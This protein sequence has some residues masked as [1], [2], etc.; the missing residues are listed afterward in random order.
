MNEKSKEDKMKYNVI[1][2]L[3]LAISFS[4]VQSKEES[5]IHNLHGSDISYNLLSNKF[6]DDS[7]LLDYNDAGVIAIYLPDTI[8][9]GD[10]VRPF[11]KIKNFGSDTADI[12]TRMKI[13]SSYNQVRSKTLGPGNEDT[14][15]FPSWAAFRVAWMVVVCSTELLGDQNPE[16]DRLTDTIYVRRFTYDIGIETIPVPETIN[17]AESAKVTIRNYGM[18]RVLDT[19]YFLFQLYTRDTVPVFILSFSAFL[20]LTP[21]DTARVGNP[22]PPFFPDEEGILS[23]EIWP[24]NDSNPHNNIKFK[25]FF[26]RFPAIQ[27]P[28]RSLLYSSP[29]K[30]TVMRINQFRSSI[31]KSEPE[32]NIFGSDGRRIKVEGMK[33]GIY[34]IKMRTNVKKVIIVK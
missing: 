15:T 31:I 17:L 27:E 19:C 8:G 5:L 14:V 29:F 2:L 16:N 13:G 6:W 9:Y 34:F 4:Q 18:S 26:I 7:V 1:F 3:S 23:Y 10:R 21:D 28:R 24:V 22:L 20:D 33:E 30:A 32:P 12:P 11:A 25:R